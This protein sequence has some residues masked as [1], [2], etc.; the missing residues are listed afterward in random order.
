MQRWN[1]PKS[2][3]TPLPHHK[4]PVPR[5]LDFLADQNAYTFNVRTMAASTP[6][7]MMN[8][9][10]ASPIAFHVGHL[11]N[12]HIREAPV[13]VGGDVLGIYEDLGPGD[14]GKCAENLGLNL[15]GN[16]E[17]LNLQ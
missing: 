14:E 8:S 11:L 2:S 12:P 15:N 16:V 10:V 5:K 17:I 4:V 6:A 1:Q 7:K 3:A 9:P 13:E